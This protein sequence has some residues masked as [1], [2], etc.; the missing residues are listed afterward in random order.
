MPFPQP[1][2]IGQS[3]AIKKVLEITQKVS[4]VD[5]NV[6][7]TG[8]SGVGKEL[9]A[10]SLHYYSARAEKPFIKVNS[11]ALPS[12]L[13]ESELFGYEKGAFTGAEKRKPGKFEH[14]EQGSIFLDE[15]GELPLLLQAKLLQ[16]LHD[17]RYHRIGGRSEVEVKA[18]V[19]AATN[20]NLD[21]EICQGQFRDDLYYRLSTISIHIPPLRERK[22][23]IP[24]LVD[25]FLHKIG[26]ENHLKELRIPEGLMQ[27]FL[28]YHWPGNVRELENFLYRL[29]ILENPQELEEEI[30]GNMRKPERELPEAVESKKGQSRGSAEALSDELESFPSLREVR[31][32]AV[33][34][35]EKEIIEK[36]LRRTNWNRKETARILQ[37]S[38]RAL[39]YKIKEMDLHPP[40]K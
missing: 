35:V 13:I 7:I 11:A 4:N 28:E 15:I 30:L 36:V 31:D 3:P 37:I 14:A 8:E 5:L 19:I 23:D 20:Q 27:L 6:L 12:E 40:Y 24:L 21:S 38:Y 1:R 33:K 18:R 16:V 25:H 39:L 22:D 32:Q 29:C 17:R 34:R 9:V 10:R 2:V 26:V